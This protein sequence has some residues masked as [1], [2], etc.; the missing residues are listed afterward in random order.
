MI[1]WRH[2]RI[3]ERLRCF[4]LSLFTLGLALHNADNPPAAIAA[5]IVTAL[6]LVRLK[7]ELDIR[8]DENEPAFERKLHRI[9]QIN[10]LAIAPAV[11]GL[12][13]IVRRLDVG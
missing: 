3:F 1:D 13:A 5:I 11:F 8:Q 2:P 4:G 9:E 6:L 10:S 7:I 12:I